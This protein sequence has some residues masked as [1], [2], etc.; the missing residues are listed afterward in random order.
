MKTI[1]QE[2]FT[3]ALNI[4]FKEAFEG[5]Q[6][7]VGNIFLDRDVGIFSTLGNIEADKA[8]IEYGSTT[9]AAQCEHVRFY[10]ELMNNF[11]CNNYRMMDYN[12]SWKIKTVDEDDW[13]DLRQ[14]LA[15]MYQ[16][17]S[18]TFKQSDEWNLD[19]ITI[20]MGMLTHTAY[21]LGAIRQLAKNL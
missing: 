9:I 3:Q 17:V 11:L 12:L 21:H 19:T 18:D 5:M 15:R 2:D 4:L 6:G 1:A 10:L 16:T 8:S 7:S 14:N 20:A 13:D